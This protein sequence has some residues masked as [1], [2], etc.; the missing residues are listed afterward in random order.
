MIVTF[1][2][3]TVPPSLP[4][5]IISHFAN[6]DAYTLHTSIPFLLH[7]LRTNKVYSETVIGVVSNSDLRVPSILQSLGVAVKNYPQSGSD[8]IGGENG[9]IDFVTL[10]YNVGV[11]KPDSRIFAAALEVAKKMSC[12]EEKEWAKVHVGD[13]YEKDVMAAQSAGWVG[14]MWDGERKP[15]QVLD[16]ILAG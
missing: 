6:K 1:A 13:D 3:K 14:L 10:S 5:A 2:P 16:N 7:T 12:G 4:P 8:G 9:T 15:E 11:E